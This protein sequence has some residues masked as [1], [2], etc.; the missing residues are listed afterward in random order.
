MVQP[1]VPGGT[2]SV[3]YPPRRSPASHWVARA[4]CDVTRSVAVSTL[5]PRREAVWGRDGTN[6]KSMKMTLRKAKGEKSAL[7]QARVGIHGA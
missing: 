5:W 3:D 2:L 4:V 1:A 6:A 7:G